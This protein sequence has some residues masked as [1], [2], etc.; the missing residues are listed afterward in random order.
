MAEPARK[1]PRMQVSDAL[2]STEEDPR[3][4]APNPWKAPKATRKAVRELREIIGRYGKGPIS[5]TALAEQIMV[6]ISLLDLFQI[7]LDLSRA[8]R[9]IS[10]W[11]NLKKAKK[12]SPAKDKPGTAAP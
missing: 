4:P 6:P 3:A 7:S 8:F 2:N 12:Q 9:K 11:V 5:Y 1:R 10:T